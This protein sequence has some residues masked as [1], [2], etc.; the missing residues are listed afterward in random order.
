MV[1]SDLLSGSTE[2]CTGTVTVIDARHTSRAPCQIAAGN[3]PPRERLATRCRAGCREAAAPR[4]AVPLL[5]AVAKRQ[6]KDY[7]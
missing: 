2:H 3:F 7:F 1:H 5:Y 6:L 4:A